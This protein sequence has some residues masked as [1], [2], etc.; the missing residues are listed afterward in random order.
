MRLYGPGLLLGTQEY[1]LSYIPDADSDSSLV[2][3]ALKTGDLDA[4]ICLWQG[5]SSWDSD[6]KTVSVR[7]N[8]LLKSCV[9][10]SNRK[11]DVSRPWWNTKMI[12]NLSIFFKKL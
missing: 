10:S 5:I 2:N 3:I 7:L 12:L 4:S 1:T 8:P 9:K 11:F 6:T